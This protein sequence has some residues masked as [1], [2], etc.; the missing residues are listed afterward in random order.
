M[1]A[2]LSVWAVGVVFPGQLLKHY[3]P[4]LDVFRVMR[5]SIP[6]TAARHGEAVDDLN[7]GKLAEMA[8][9]SAVIDFAG[10]LKALEPLALAYLD[11]SRRGDAAEAA[12]GL[13]EGLRWAEG[14][15]SAERL[16]IS[17]VYEDSSPSSFNKWW[18]RAR[19]ENMQPIQS[20][21]T[22]Q[23]SDPLH[24]MIVVASRQSLF[25]QRF[26]KRQQSRKS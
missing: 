21:A 23:T 20:S 15:A 19:I 26:C 12:A 4:D 14:Q 17:G 16:L 8:K 24:P 9:T 11:L 7:G 1:P 10:Q 13:F 2:C 6:A 18:T 22:L 25:G 5:R 3:S